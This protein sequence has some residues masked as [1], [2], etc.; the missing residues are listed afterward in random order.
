MKLYLCFCF[1][2]ACTVVSYHPYPSKIEPFWSNEYKRQQ[3]LRIDDRFQRELLYGGFRDTTSLCS[4]FVFRPYCVD[5]GTIFL[6][7]WGHR[8]DIGW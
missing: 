1:L 7:H 3:S 8:R 2:S 4:D 6:D 5:N